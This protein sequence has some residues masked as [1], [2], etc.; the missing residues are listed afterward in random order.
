MGLVVR[1]T[2]IE[3]GGKTGVGIGFAGKT[4]AEWRN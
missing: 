4:G 2:G 3:F 1:Q